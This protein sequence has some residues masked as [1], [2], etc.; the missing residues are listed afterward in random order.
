MA[1]SGPEQAAG[2]R[3]RT[4]QWERLLRNSVRLGQGACPLVLHA[5]RL[6]TCHE[7]CDASLLGL[8][9]SQPAS[10]SHGGALDQL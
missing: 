8:V 9:G 1:P 5:P 6:H 7:I 3:Q 4:Q 10:H 2:V